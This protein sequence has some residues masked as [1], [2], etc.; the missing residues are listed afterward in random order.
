MLVT[1]CCRREQV[2]LLMMI[3]RRVT[4]YPLAASRPCTTSLEGA[5]FGWSSTTVGGRTEADGVDDGGASG[6]GRTLTPPMVRTSSEVG[7][8]TFGPL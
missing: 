3:R 8:L 6:T 7:T 4:S 1:S 5:G 2:L